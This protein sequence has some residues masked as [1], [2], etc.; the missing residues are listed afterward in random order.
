MQGKRVI[1]V[2]KTQEGIQRKLH[3]EGYWQAPKNS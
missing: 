2:R 3:A 1:V